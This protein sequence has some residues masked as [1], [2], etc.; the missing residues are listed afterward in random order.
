LRYIDLVNKVLDES[1]KEQNPL[2][3]ANLDSAEAGRRLYPRVK[4]LV[5]EAWKM[6]QMSRNEWEFNSGEVV[7]TIPPKLKFVTGS[8]P[9][10]E[11][12]GLSVWTGKTSGA[13]ITV[14]AV[15]TTDGLWEDGDAY[16]QIEFSTT[17]STPPIIGEVFEDGLDGSFEYTGVGSYAISYGPG[18]VREPRWDTVKARRPGEGYVNMQF[19]PWTQFLLG[20]FT[21]GSSSAVPY[22]FSQDYLGNLVFYAQT[23]Q[24]FTLSFVYDM[25]PQDLTEAEDVPE[26]LPL[27]Y[28]DWIAWEALI[29]LARFDKDPDLYGYAQSMATVYRQRAERNLMPLIEWETS[30]YN[31]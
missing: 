29:N 31:R 10:G 11:P 3:V 30:R 20:G 8:N 22:Y 6:L 25:A 16:G 4:R 14:S 18:R 17:G 9:A 2:N 24:P 7:L 26:G 12:A 23:L 13:V 15:T 21:Y 27:E 28:H 5:R 19:V 1:G